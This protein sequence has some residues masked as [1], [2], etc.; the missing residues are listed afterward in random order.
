MYASATAIVRMARELL[1]RNMDTTLRD[2]CLTATKIYE[3]GIHGD[4]LAIEVFKTMGAYLGVGIANL[5]NILGPEV[6][7]IGGGVAN[8][9]T[10]FE[11]AMQEQVLKRASRALTPM[12]KINPALCGD[13][14][15][16]LG[17][18]QLAWT[19]PERISDLRFQ[20]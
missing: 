15:G 6:I 8:G 9:W 19:S 7:V 10:L 20:I 12:P 17:A 18:A 14:A 5:I 4:S 2:E 11:A 3:A 1:S 16:L 13:N